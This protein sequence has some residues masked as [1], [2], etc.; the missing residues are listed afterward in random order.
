MISMN[1][2]S[3]LNIIVPCFNPL[4]NWQLELI[5]SF[6]VIQELLQQTEIKIIL[7]NDGSSKN[8]DKDIKFLEKNIPNFHFIDLKTNNGKGFAIRQGFKISNA[9]CTVFTD[10]D[11]P[12]KENNLIEMVSKIE[13]GAD[14]VIGI[15]KENYYK[16][17]PFIR[18]NLSL[19]FKKILK[20]LFKIPTSD[21]QAGLKAFSKNMKHIVLETKVNRYLFDL[22]LIKLANKNKKIKFDYVDLSLKDDIILSQMSLSILFKEFKNLIKILFS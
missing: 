2:D 14:F 8:L 6:N 15:R 17:I 1:K 7:V 16:K 3:T 22:E 11:F 10:I 18:K 4:E 9:D 20:F 12:Y 5:K 13:N 21:T 19:T